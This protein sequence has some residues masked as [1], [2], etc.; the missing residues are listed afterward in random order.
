VN[1]ATYLPGGPKLDPEFKR[2][3]VAALRSGDYQQGESWLRK[4]LPDGTFSYCCVDVGCNIRSQRKGWRA[5]ETLD[6][7]SGDYIT[8]FDWKSGSDAG[9]TTGLDW[10]DDDTF[11]LLATF[12][13][14]EKKSFSEIADWVEKNL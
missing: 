8:V 4:L 1:R 10:L 11:H 13:D 7:D 5:R 12:N 9:L 14:V 2:Q 6:R 3:F